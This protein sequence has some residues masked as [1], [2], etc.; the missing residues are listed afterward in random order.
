M[1]KTKSGR[2]V[3]CLNRRA[4]YDYTITETL[5]AG[6]M[7]VGTEVKSLRQGQASIVEAYAG[8]KDGALYLLNSF[9]P[10]YSHGTMFNHEPKRPRKILVKRREMSRLLGAIARKGVTLVPLSIYFNERGIAKL[11]LGLATGKRK[12]EKRQAEKER[13]WKREKER[14]IKRS[15]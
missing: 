5:E 3:V 10:E 15:E 4:R 1:A 11:E 14:I 13:D 2:K 12:V 9:I 8:E 6:L 7:L